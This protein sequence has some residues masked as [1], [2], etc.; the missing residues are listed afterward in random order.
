MVFEAS[1]R[2]RCNMFQVAFLHRIELI[3]SAW[4][5]YHWTASGESRTERGI[6]LNNQPSVDRSDSQ[7]GCK[8]QLIT[9]RRIAYRYGD[10]LCT[11][12]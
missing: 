12:R 3:V 5:I 1:I 4:G 11:F 10:G 8:S 7:R 2:C 6:S 9:Q